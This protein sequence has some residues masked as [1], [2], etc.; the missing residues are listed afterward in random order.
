MA[1]LAKEQMMPELCGYLR[2]IPE[3]VLIDFEVQ[4]VILARFFGLITK[5]TLKL[6]YFSKKTPKNFGPTH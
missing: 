6:M 2:D 1:D 3:F 4:G 5:N